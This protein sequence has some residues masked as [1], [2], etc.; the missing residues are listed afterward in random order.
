MRISSAAMESYSA[1]ERTRVGALIFD[2]P[3][4]ADRRVLMV[5]DG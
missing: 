1:R 4:G 5:E 3:T 2:A